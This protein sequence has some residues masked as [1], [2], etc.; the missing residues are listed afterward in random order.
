VRAGVVALV[1]LSGCAQ[2]KSTSTVQIRPR[3]N[4]TA[5]ML[6]GPSQITTR[7]AAV[8]WEQHASTLEVRVVETR[9]C[10]EVRHRPVERI[11]HVDRK[12]GAAI[13]W[14][15]GLGAAALA[16][17]LAALIRP[18]FLSPEVERQTGGA[19]KDT[20][21]GYRVGGIFTA[22]GAVF[23]AAGVVDTVRSR[24]V[25]YT[26]E[27]YEVELGERIECAAPTLP[28][29]HAKVEVIVD[30]WRESAR[31]DADGKVTFALPA[32]LDVAAKPEP[33]APATTSE[34]GRGMPEVSAVPTGA[35]DVR[36]GVIRLDA[37]R[38]T[39]F[40]IAVPFASANEAGEATLGKPI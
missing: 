18:E 40:E 30:D 11:E 14:E 8:Q 36:R 32:E 21:T 9:H 5:V 33:E 25:T 15:Y 2:I 22:L 37:R 35:S 7:G 10:R 34:D 16:F 38:A 12:A 1:V 23:I 31:T 28:L 24:D 29:S 19:V 20:R 6:G 13:Y 4:A 17:G 26:S 39:S 3:P 27:A